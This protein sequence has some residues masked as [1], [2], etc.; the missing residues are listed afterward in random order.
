MEDFPVTSNFL[1]VVIVYIF[2]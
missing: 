2:Y 1:S